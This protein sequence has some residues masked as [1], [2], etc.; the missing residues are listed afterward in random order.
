MNSPDVEMPTVKLDV[1]VIVFLVQFLASPMN[2]SGQAQEYEPKE[3]SQ[4]VFG[5]SQIVEFSEHSSI[6]M[7]VPPDG[8]VPSKHNTLQLNP[9]PSNPS[10]QMHP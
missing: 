4:I 5:V 9:S 3:F 7:H 8:F 1:V 2:P 10:S 6:S